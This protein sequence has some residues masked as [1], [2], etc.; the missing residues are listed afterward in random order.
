MG[1]DLEL[2]FRIRFWGEF[3]R[4]GFAPCQLA[5]RQLLLTNYYLQ[6]KFQPG[7][8]PFTAMVV[9]IGPCSLLLIS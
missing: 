3:L 1:N 7:G 9:P 6:I 8:L 4:L 5:Y 2:G